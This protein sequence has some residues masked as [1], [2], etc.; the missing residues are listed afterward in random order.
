MFFHLKEPEMRGKE[1]ASSNQ[2]H[3]VKVKTYNCM[4]SPNITV[5]FLLHPTNLAIFLRITPVTMA[6]VLLRT[7]T[8]HCLFLNFWPR[9][10]KAI[11]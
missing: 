11:A 8:L 6:M 7:G 3:P 10:W 5:F 4:I 2:P 9:S 1:L